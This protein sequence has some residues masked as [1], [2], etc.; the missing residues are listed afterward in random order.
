VSFKLLNSIN[1]LQKKYSEWESYSPT[2]TGSSSNPAAGTIE[3]LFARWRRVGDSI[4][5]HFKFETSTAS[6]DAGAGI[7]LFSLPSGLAIDQ[8][9]VTVS[10][11][12]LGSALGFCNGHNGVE[13]GT[14]VVQAGD[15]T[16]LILLM[17][18]D[19]EVGV[20]LVQ[21]AFFD[22]NAA[23]MYSFHATVPILGWDG[24]I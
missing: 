24:R 7:Y 20:A 22:T 2:I 8:D 17:M 3:Q 15:A 18:N 13:F 12:G 1:K 23:V 16:H 6:G 14:G 21:A 11:T 4:D 10:I 9:K 5:V 19:N